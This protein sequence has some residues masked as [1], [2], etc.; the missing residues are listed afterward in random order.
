MCPGAAESPVLPAEKVTILCLKGDIFTTFSLE[1]HKYIFINSLLQFL[2]CSHLKRMFSSIINK[3]YTYNPLSPVVLPSYLRIG[4]AACQG[5][6]HCLRE[7]TVPQQQGLPVALLLWRGVFKTL[8]II[9]GCRLLGSC[10]GNP[11]V[12][13]HGSNTLALS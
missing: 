3:H 2:P 10:A 11:I 1:F 13:I 4:W 12:K 7:L 5:I 8:L 6:H 9:H